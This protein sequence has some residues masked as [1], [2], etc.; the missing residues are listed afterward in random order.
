MS[1]RVNFIARRSGLGESSANSMVSSVSSN[2][3]RQNV[4]QAQE[5][6][7]QKQQDEAR[8]VRN[9]QQ[10]STLNAQHKADQDQDQVR[11]D[12]QNSQQA[13]G[14]SLDVRA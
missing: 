5:I 14:A 10:P 4:P 9:K 2:D 11:T 13:K 1:F 3:P 12:K 6:Q 8:N 7:H